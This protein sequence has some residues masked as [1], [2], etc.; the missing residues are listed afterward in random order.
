MKLSLIILSLVFVLDSFQQNLSGPVEVTPSVECNFCSVDSD[1]F[2]PSDCECSA[3]LKITQSVYCG[4]ACDAIKYCCENITCLMCETGVNPTG[5]EN[6]V[7]ENSALP[8]EVRYACGP[9]CDAVGYCCEPPAE[10]STSTKKPK[11]KC[12]PV[13]KST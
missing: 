10:T 4:P 7:C 13:Q 5:D 6:C 1:I 8:K 12:R 2:S 9:A 3:S 11:Y